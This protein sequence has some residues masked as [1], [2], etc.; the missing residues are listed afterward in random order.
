MSY[1]SGVGASEAPNDRNVK[2]MYAYRFET[3]TAMKAM[4]V[5]DK[6]FRHEILEPVKTKPI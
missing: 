5:H 1:A 6:S 2:I 3:V 4:N